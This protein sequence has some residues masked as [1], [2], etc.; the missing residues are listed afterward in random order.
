MNKF[1]KIT[2]AAIVLSGF[3]AAAS[4]QADSNVALNKAVTLNGTFETGGWSGA[5]HSAAGSVADGLFLP[6]NTEWDRG[7]VWWNASQ[8]GAGANSIVIDLAGRYALTTFTLQADNNDTYRIQ[9]NNAG[10]WQTAVDFGA[11]GGYGLM[12]RKSGLLPTIFTD[13]LRITAIAGDNAFGV[14]EVQA[15]GVAAAVPE[16]ATYALMLA[17]LAL[18]GFAAR[19][20]N[21]A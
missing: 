21:G 3:A 4:A 18:L 16:P 10:V 14:S 8:P 13:K 15:F 6:E 12:T 20:R 1:K 7:S 17:G 5:T 19:R 11:I 2:L 9:Y